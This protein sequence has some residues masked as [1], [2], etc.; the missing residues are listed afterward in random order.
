MHLDFIAEGWKP[1]LDAMEEWLNTRTFPMEVTNK[2]GEKMTVIAPAA[3]R[4]RRAYTYVFPR[5]GLDIVLNTLKPQ[6]G[7]HLVD[8]KR[9]RVLKAPLAILRKS[10]RLKKIPKPDESKGTFPM[11]MNNIR[12]IG[13]G[14]RED[15][16]FTN[17]AGITQESL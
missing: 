6:E 1:D 16:D 13:L 3:L 4:P 2:E 8:G 15:I 11:V 17:D 12:F 5:T 7:I 9:T 10:L 14:I